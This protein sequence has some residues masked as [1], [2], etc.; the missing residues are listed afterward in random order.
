[1]SVATSASVPAVLRDL[2]A[3]SA[4]DL[5]AAYE[6]R[7]ESV[8][9]RPESHTQRCSI[10]GFTGDTLCGSVVIA[11]TSE[12]VA[13]SNPIQDGPSAAWLGELANQLVGRFKNLLLKLRVEIMMSI[14]VVLNAVKIEPV[15]QQSIAPIH[16]LVGTGSMTIWVE[17]EGTPVF[18]DASQQIG[19]VEG[20][21]MMF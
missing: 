8:D 13:S 16:L 21:V 14:P 11:A 15:P 4:A 7:C 20:E 1:M 2:M 18:R 9:E 5:F 12:A 3:K 10:L 6:V 17:Y 19:I